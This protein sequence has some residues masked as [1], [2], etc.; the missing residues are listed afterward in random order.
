MMASPEKSEGKP[1]DAPDPGKAPEAPPEAPPA[2]TPPEPSEG[3]TAPATEPV[4]ATVGDLPVAALQDPTHPQAPAGPS[5]G[6]P[7]SPSS[8]MGGQAA[9]VAA[10]VAEATVNVSELAAAIAV[11]PIPAY[12]KRGLAEH[13]RVKLELSEEFV[14][15]TQ[16]LPPTY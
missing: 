16:T 6:V 10:D 4:G 3:P 11:A 9:V 15:A 1:E 7:L 2:E 14:L 5:P 12:D 13:L 8:V